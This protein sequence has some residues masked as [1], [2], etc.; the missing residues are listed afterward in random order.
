MRVRGNICKSSCKNP[1]N[2]TPHASANTGISKNLEAN[3]AKIIKE[4]CSGRCFS[5]EEKDSISSYLID[6]EKSLTK[7]FERYSREQLTRELSKI[8]YDVL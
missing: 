6:G 1:A 7:N 4:T 5:Y 2:K 3:T 8:L